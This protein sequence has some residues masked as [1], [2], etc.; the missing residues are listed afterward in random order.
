MIAIIREELGRVESGR[1]DLRPQG[2][3]R[4][5]LVFLYA[6]L[7]VW[8]A[9]WFFH[10]G[11]ESFYRQFFYLLFFLPAAV[12]ALTQRSL[13]ASFARGRAFVLTTA[14]TLY[15]SL[16][17]VYQ[18][19][20]IEPEDVRDAVRFAV[21][22]PLLL[23]TWYMIRLSVPRAAPILIG[24]LTMA[25]LLSA[26]FLGGSWLT[27]VGPAAGN[28][29]LDP[30]LAFGWNTNRL[31]SL[32]A[33]PLAGGLALGLGSGRQWLRILGWCAALAAAVIIFWTQS[34]QGMIAAVVMAVVMLAYYR[35]WRLLAALLVAAVVVGAA[36]LAG[37]LGSRDLTDSSS[38]HYRWA[39]YQSVL[40]RIGE[41]P[42]LGEG[43]M[44]STA[45]ETRFGTWPHAHNTYLHV[46]LHGGIVSLGL[47]LALLVHVLHMGLTMLRDSGRNPGTMT[48]LYSLGILVY[49]LVVSLAAV[50][51]PFMKPTTSWILFWMP[52][53]LIAADNHLHG[54]R[55]H[56]DAIK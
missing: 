31:A 33:I 46:W 9:G 45:I 41:R 50:R 22:I 16:S 30:E 19:Q 51:D 13:L 6:V 10:F 27:D 18:V 17:L 20:P 5:L 21:M 42:I 43:W 25:G 29:R 36:A 48:I 28:A 54:V 7:C 34:R 47:F 38:I 32:F 4:L 53:A 1:N 15:A 12:L 2:R 37:M 3:A 55:G 11:D 44:V 8:L 49:F 56:T 24:V 39:I 35:R 40:D 52:V 14:F 23:A 26:L